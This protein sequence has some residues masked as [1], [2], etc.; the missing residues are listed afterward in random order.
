[1]KYL[2]IKYW[3][4]LMSRIRYNTKEVSLLARLMRAEALGEGKQGMLL[5]GN[6]GVNRV[7]AKC[8]VFKK[9]TTI[10]QMIYQ[11]PSGFSAVESKLFYGPAGKVEKDLAKKVIKFWRAKPAYRALFFK[12]PGKNKPCPKNFWGPLAGK[13]KQHCFYNPSNPKKCGI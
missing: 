10:Q 13:Y 8:G 1:M 12:N 9:I 2:H 4:G 11:K 3:G 6:V 5:V 7:C